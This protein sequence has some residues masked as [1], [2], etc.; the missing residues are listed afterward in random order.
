MRVESVLRRPGKPAL[1]RSIVLAAALMAL[2][3]ALSVATLARLLP[4]AEWGRL[5]DPD[6][7]GDI[8]VLLARDSLFPRMAISLLAGAGLALAGVLYQAVLRNPL[9]EPS[10][11]G[12]AAGAQ[13]ALV[14]VT[15]WYPAAAGTVGAEGVAFAGSLAALLLVMAVG[16]SRQFSPTRVIIAGVFASLYAGAASGVLVLF[17]QH[18]LT[19]VFLWGSGSLVQN[20]WEASGGLLLRLSIAGLLAA[21][22]LRPLRLLSIGDESAR[23]LG[24]GVAPLRVATLL[25]ATG[26]SAAVVSAAGMIAFIGL[27]APAIARAAGAR[28]MAAQLRAAPLVGAGL[29]WVTDQMVQLAPLPREIPTGAATA[30]LGAPLL[31]WLLPRMGAEGLPRAQQAEGPRRLHRPD[32]ALAALLV[33][34]VLLFLCAL[35]F[36]RGPGGWAWL[37]G[38]A[39]K[40]MLP[41][42]WPRVVSAGMAGAMLAAAG[43]VIQRMTANP[44][45]SPEILG[46]S[47]GAAL[48]LIALLFLVPAPSHAWQLAATTC[49]AFLSLLAIL[50]S[51]RRTRFAPDRLLLVGIAFGTL[52]SALAAVLMASGDPRMAMLLGWMVGSTYAVTQMRAV[53]TAGVGVLLL[54]LLALAVRPLGIL[55]LGEGVASS[56]G[57]RVAA[58][59]LGLLAVT[60]GLTAAATLAVG[61]LTFVGLLAPHLTRLA[62][63]NRPA[64]HLLASSLAGAVVMIAADWAGRSV[65][66]PYQIPAGLFASFLAGPFFLLLLRRER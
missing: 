20:G 29:L 50:A 19:G 23:S 36:G 42:R 46:V 43:V 31:L 11:L 7:S 10:T 62:G 38:Q 26:L 58:V 17:N 5:P 24:I 30:L 12:V 15:L 27:A 64:D 37:T 8:A 48:G 3:A 44:L 56:L 40:D 13:L 41:W 39:L 6:G 25:V 47:S 66:F 4:V 22:L 54:A 53:V 9:A 59:R 55:P 51:G 35:A 2:G 65:I 28:T 49:G 63:F 57:M 52:L 45:A 60:A 18:Y 1:D 16:W 33:L 21:A 32:L 61:P 34:A 14:V